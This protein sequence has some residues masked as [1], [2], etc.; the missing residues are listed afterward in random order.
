MAASSAR[1]Q[2]SRSFIIDVVLNSE[3]IDTMC[4]ICHL[5]KAIIKCKQCFDHF[6]AN[7]DVSMHASYALHYRS[8]FV[9]GYESPLLPTEIINDSLNVELSGI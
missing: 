6:C 1:S 8:S 9:D 4:D 7:C 2:Q 3:I 5:K